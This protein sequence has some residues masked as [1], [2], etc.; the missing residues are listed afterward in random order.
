MD[1]VAFQLGPLAIRWYGI[2]VALGFIV[3]LVFVER[4]SGRA[5]MRSEQV[6]NLVFIGLIG[7]LLGARLFYVLHNLVYFRANPWETIRLDHGGLV[8]YGGLIGGTL[9]LLATCL[10]RRLPMG[11]VADMLIPGLP[12]GHA[13]GRIGCFLNGCCFGQPWSGA[14]GI[15]YDA[16]SQAAARQC[17]QGLIAAPSLAPLPV[18]P[19]QL[20]AAIANLAIFFGL[21]AVE[22]RLRGRGQLL[23][24][25]IAVYGF[26]RFV[27]EFLRGDYLDAG[28]LTP[29]QEVSLVLV[30]VGVAVF[31]LRRGREETGVAEAEENA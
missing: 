11:R 10:L 17:Q 4:R 28:M 12:L 1:P 19:V 7:G 3:G 9:S 21:L 13:L 18:F 30:P 26:Y 31:L 22:R 2:F 29:A 6:A 15:Q 20:L 24:L 25:Y 16:G 8:F 14:C 27:I 5:G 23:G